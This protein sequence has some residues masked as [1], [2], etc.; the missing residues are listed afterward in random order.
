MSFERSRP[1][2]SVS[3]WIDK[4]STLIYEPLTFVATATITLSQNSTTSVSAFKTSG[5]FNWDAQAYCLTPFTAPCTLEFNKWSANNDNSRSYAMIGWNNDPTT[6]ASYDTINY[7]AYPYAMSSYQVYNN[8]TFIAPTISTWSRL[9]KF[10]IVYG[11]D[12]FIRHY[13]G[14]TQLYSVNYGVGNT[15]Y[16][17]SSLHSVG[18]TFG[19]FSNMRVIK[20]AWNGT[21]YT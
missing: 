16:V 7:A 9:L 13:N 2:S 17:D 14:S 12:G 20:K 18:A 6:N 3:G 19:G 1:S 11:T 15:V 8:G 4:S 21:S 5:A 10:Y